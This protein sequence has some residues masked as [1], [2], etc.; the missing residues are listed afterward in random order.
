MS[1]FWVRI[2]VF[3]KAVLDRFWDRP[4]EEIPPVLVLEPK[5]EKKLSEDKIVKRAK[6]YLIRIEW[7]G[8]KRLMVKEVRTQP[9]RL[10]EQRLSIDEFDDVLIPKLVKLVPTNTRTWQG[11]VLHHSLT[12]DGLVPDE[13]AITRYHTSWRHKG[14]II[15]EAEAKKIIDFDDGETVT[16]PWS[17]NGYNV[18]VEF[19]DDSITIFLARPLSRTGAHT[20]QNRRNLTHIGLCFIGNFDAVEPK[21]HKLAVGA[22]VCK[23]YMSKYGFNTDNIDTHRVHA[24]YKTCPGEKFVYEEFTGK[25]IDA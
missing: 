2:K 13:E 12:K 5:V 7:G 24:T 11:V 17:D 9:L 8:K 18:L 10:L 21:G 3:L 23:A 6:E 20:K 19:V 16:P 15:T 1:N 4:H 14:N 25:Y 22:S